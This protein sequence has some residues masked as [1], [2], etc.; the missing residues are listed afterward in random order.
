MVTDNQQKD[1]ILAAY[2]ASTS[3]RDSTK[4][5][6]GFVH[7]IHSEGKYDQ[8]KHWWDDLDAL[9]TI[10]TAEHIRSRTTE[11]ERPLDPIENPVVGA[12][13]DC[14]VNGKANR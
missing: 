1:M 13:R 6:E 7:W 3:L 2:F 4:D 12:K 11:T 8:L 14:P 5:F 10:R 9:R